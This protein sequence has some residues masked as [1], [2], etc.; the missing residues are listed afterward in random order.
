MNSGMNSL[1]MIKRKESLLKKYCQISVMAPR[2]KV[3]SWKTGRYL[4][5]VV[6]AQ[7]STGHLG[8]VITGTTRANTASMETG[9][10]GEVQGSEGEFLDRRVLER[11]VKSL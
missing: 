2:M 9:V 7:S 3:G 6:G 8:M 4:A 11:R 10:T 1:R 5:P